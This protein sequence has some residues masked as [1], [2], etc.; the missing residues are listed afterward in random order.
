MKIQDCTLFDTDL[1]IHR[2]SNDPNVRS[3]AKKEFAESRPSAMSIFSM[4]ELKG[5]Y[6]QSLILLH[7]KISNSDSLEIAF[8]RIQN[9]GGRKSG[10]MLSQLLNVLGGINFKIKPWSEAKNQLITILDS[11]IE[12][13][14]GVFKRS[15]DTVLNDFKCTRAEE[16]PYDNNGKWNAPIH[17]CSES[18]T[19]CNVE[20]FLKKYFDELAKLVH[21]ITH[22]SE[23]NSKTKELDQMLNVSKRILEGRPFLKENWTCRKIGDLL[24]GLQSKVVSELISSNYKEHSILSTSLGYSFREFPIVKIRSI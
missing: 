12:G 22:L 2:L 23:D 6:I 11:Q 4:L 16:A 7:R 24:I 20:N 17:R 19:H 18:N 15:V 10:L 9:S 13:S 14:R 8:A 1:Q 3:A 5:N 21:T